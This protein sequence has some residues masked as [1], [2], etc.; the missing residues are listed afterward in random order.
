[1]GEV[2]AFVERAGEGEFF[3]QG[4]VPEDDHIELAV[5][6]VRVGGDEHAAAE[7]APVGDGDVEGGALVEHAPVDLHADPLVAVAQRR[8]ERAEEEGGLAA[9]PLGPLVDEL[10]GVAADAEAGDVEE[11]PERRGAPLVDEAQGA[12]IHGASGAAQ[13]PHGLLHAAGE[14]QGALEI[15]AG[16]RGDHREVGAAEGLAVLIDVRLD[17]LVEGAVA[18]HHGEDLDAVFPGDTGQAP[19]VSRARGLGDIVLQALASER[20]SERV[21]LA[22]RCAGASLG[23]EQQTDRGGC[24]GWGLPGEKCSEPPGRCLTARGRSVSW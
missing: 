16:A 18:P 19:G 4:E 24:H 6:E 8:P 2:R 10:V 22:Q 3:R 9:E 21:E 1:V 13:A 5:G 12:E 20:L 23:V 15:A 11:G 7:V 14:A 17:G